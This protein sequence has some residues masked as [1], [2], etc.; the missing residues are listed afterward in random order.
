MASVGRVQ[1]QASGGAAESLALMSNITT[2]ASGHAFLS[3]PPALPSWLNSNSRPCDRACYLTCSSSLLSSIPTGRHGAI[4][5][6]TLAARNIYMADGKC[7]ENSVSN[8]SSG[9]RVILTMRGTDHLWPGQP[10][11]SAASSRRPSN[12]A[13]ADYAAI[14]SVFAFR[15]AV[16]RYLSG[17]PSG[18]GTRP[19]ALACIY[20]GFLGDGS[21][22]LPFPEFFSLPHIEAFVE[23]GELLAGER[24]PSFPFPFRFPSVRVQGREADGFAGN[25][26]T[27]MCDSL[28]SELEGYNVVTYLWRGAACTRRWER[29][30]GY[31]AGGSGALRQAAW[32][33]GWRCHVR[34]DWRGATTRVWSAWESRRKIPCL[35]RAADDLKSGGRAG[36]SRRVAESRGAARRGATRRAH[37]SRYVVKKSSASNWESW[38]SP[39]ECKGAARGVTSWNRIVS[40]CRWSGLAFVGEEN[41]TCYGVPSA[42]SSPSPVHC[43]GGAEGSRRVRGRGAAGSQDL[44]K[45]GGGCGV[46]VWLREGAVTQGRERAALGTRRVFKDE[47]EGAPL[48]L[49]WWGGCGCTC[50]GVETHR[51]RL[52]FTSK[53]GVPHRLC[54]WVPSPARHPPPPSL[55]RSSER[56]WEAASLH[57]SSSRLVRPRLSYA[58]SQYYALT[59]RASTPRDFS[60][61]VQEAGYVAGTL[62]LASEW[63][64]AAKR[65]NAKGAG[66]K[67]GVSRRNGRRATKYGWRAGERKKG[68]WMDG[69]WWWMDYLTR[70]LYGRTICLGLVILTDIKS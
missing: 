8:L 67:Q 26:P 24:N 56:V 19:A 44:R 36:R 50:R 65:E 66:R 22:F 45:R 57:S 34:A 6:V 43:V 70:L 15:H 61:S 13:L 48:S 31:G 69:L 58:F 12:P 49:V 1:K 5:K 35:I 9:A 53:A 28:N 38:T 29:G 11:P 14:G 47:A 63:W 7:Q 3:L 21:C 42:A 40:F 4:R 33:R 39:P 68:A 62:W 32:C 59:S 10:A 23:S 41:N 64:E 37:P 2:R 16:S 52:R 17:D 27:A 51:V 55:A 20:L 60:T 54:G 18:Q 25:A 46:R 30:C